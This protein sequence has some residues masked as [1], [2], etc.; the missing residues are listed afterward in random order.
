VAQ[1]ILS[2]RTY[3]LSGNNPFVFAVFLLAFLLNLAISIWVMYAADKTL[4]FGE[5]PG[6]PLIGCFPIAGGKLVGV[7]F[8]VVLAVETL[9]FVVTMWAGFVRNGFFQSASRL[10]HILYRDSLIF[11]VYVFV[12]ALA[13]VIVI[14][15]APPPLIGLLMVLQ[16]ACHCISGTRIVLNMRGSTAKEQSITNK[17]EGLEF[18]PTLKGSRSQLDKSQH[19]MLDISLDAKESASEKY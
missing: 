11:Y 17:I 18:E 6:I 10:A 4:I 14:Y 5:L 19:S 1:T 7:G 15:S 8:S 12:I 3:A 9:I 13:N 16:H 2:L